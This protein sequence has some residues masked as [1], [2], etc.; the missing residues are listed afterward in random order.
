MIYSTKPFTYEELEKIKK[1]YGS[2]LKVTADVKDEVIVVGVSLHADGE[3]ILIDNGSKQ[4]D[5]WGGGVDLRDKIIDASA[6]LNIR[7]R[8]GNDSMEILDPKIRGKFVN[9]VKKYFKRL[10]TTK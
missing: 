10:W 1:D 6:V 7:P 2:Y 3:K 9:I 5:I 4:E 8:T